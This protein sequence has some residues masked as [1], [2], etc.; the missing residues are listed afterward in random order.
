MA[1]NY[2]IKIEPIL[3]TAKLNQQL[4]ETRQLNFLTQDKQSGHHL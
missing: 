3:N 1:G 4:N 2:K